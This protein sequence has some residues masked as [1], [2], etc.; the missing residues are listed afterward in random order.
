MEK[1]LKVVRS[2]FFISAFVILLELV[3]LFIVFGLFYKYSSLIVVLGYI[4]YVGVFLYIINKYESPEFKLP[5]VIIMMLFFVFGAFAFILLTSNDQNKDLITRFKNNKEKLKPYLRQNEVLE[6]LKDKNMDAYL[7]ANYISKVT[8]LPVYQNTKVTYYKVGEEFHEALLD[9]LRNAKKFIM[10]EYF[11]IEEGKMWDSIYEVLK[12]KVNDGVKVYVIYDDF[13]CMT[14][15]DEKYYEKLNCEGI[16]CMPS[17]KFRAVMSRIHNNRDHRKITVIDGIVGFTG[18]INLADEYI[19]EK[20]KHGHWKD[21]AV[22]L[23]G[24]A[25]DSLT[26]LF[27]ETWNCQNKQII[28]LADVMNQNVYKKQADGIVVPYGDGP[29]EF[30]HDSVGK[31]VYLNMINTAKRYVYITTPYLICDYEIMNA[32]CVSSKK[33]VDVRIIVPH[34]PDKKTIFWMTQS[35]YDILIHSGVR[36]YE[37]TPGFIHAKEFISDDLFATCG[38]VNL[39]YRSLVHHFECGVWMYNISC[40]KE[41]KKDFLE[42][43]DISE[44]IIGKK[45]KLKG[46]K[47]LVTESMKIFFPLF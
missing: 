16:N 44:E 7:Q 6:R 14:T 34:I 43:L 46:W 1:L 20:V 15:L 18:G 25:V 21:T 19:N 13:G 47:K 12:K 45:V 35:N 3:Q 40:I 28:E 27:L 4:F 9:S 38:T 8:E 2:R 26:A 10:M 32:L 36:I 17:N 39:D 23:E 5:W 24:D 11:I 29:E 37:Y 30:Y 31:N 41:M 42:T 22:K 33:G